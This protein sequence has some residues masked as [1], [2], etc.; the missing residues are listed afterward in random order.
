MIRS[1]RHRE[2][3]AYDVS[4][5]LAVG[6]SI[7]PDMEDIEAL[8]LELMAPASHAEQS[9][10][11]DSDMD[12]AHYYDAM[13]DEDERCPETDMDLSS[14]PASPRIQHILSLQSTLYSVEESHSSP[15]SSQ[16]LD[17]LLSSPCPYCGAPYSLHVQ[18]AVA[19]A[20]MCAVCTSPFVLSNEAEV[21]WTASHPS[22]SSSM[23][24]LLLVSSSILTE[25][26]C[27]LDCILL[28]LFWSRP[29]LRGLF[30]FAQTNHVPGD[31]RCDHG[32]HQTGL[33]R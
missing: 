4:Y 27:H 25:C 32:R 28:W 16:F 11:P 20:L 17:S 31:L 3:H 13:L 24:V 29:C 8:E 6:S 7:D 9:P 18:E 30:C 14:P 23:C 10:P 22:S 33:E 2:K 19:P 12:E 5:R 1:E 15:P 21:S 26:I